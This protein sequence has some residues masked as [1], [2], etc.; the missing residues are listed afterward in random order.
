[1][2]L[3]NGSVTFC[4]FTNRGNVRQL[5][6]IAANHDYRAA[7]SASYTVS[8]QSTCPSRR[9]VTRLAPAG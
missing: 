4:R 1:V 5:F 9:P 6:V 3:Q 7:H 2:D 8:P